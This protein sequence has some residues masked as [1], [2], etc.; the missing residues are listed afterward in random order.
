MQREIVKYEMRNN[1]GLM[2]DERREKTPERGNRIQE[3]NNLGVPKHYN[4][5]S[6]RLKL[7]QG[8]FLRL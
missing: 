4:Y 7:W 6:R 5:R 8:R 2:Q 1:E 3:G